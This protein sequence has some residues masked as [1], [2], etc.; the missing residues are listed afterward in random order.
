MK[1][2]LLALLRPLGW[3][4]AALNQLRRT[5]YRKQI[6][7]SK[8]LPG[9]TISVGNLEVGG[10]GKTPICIELAKHLLEAGYH[11]AILTRG[12]GSGL[13][14]SDSAVLLNKQLILPPQQ[15]SKEFFA[16]EARMQ[17]HHLP[18]VPIIIG[19]K[20]FAAAKRY[21]EKQPQPTHWI[22]EDGFQH[23]Q[24]KRDLDIVLLDY[25]KPLD[26][27]RCLPAGRL[28]EAPWTLSKADL[29]IFTRSPDQP[30]LPA[31]VASYLSKRTS[32]DFASFASSLPYP[33]APDVA[34]PFSLAMS[35]GLL[36]GIAKPAQLQHELEKLSINIKESTI[37]R[38][39]EPL[40]RGQVQAL[41]KRCEQIITTEK[42]Y[43]R[44]QEAFTESLRFLY[45]IPL[46]VKLHKGFYKH[47]NKVQIFT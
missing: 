13:K 24:I 27:G 26:N 44:S 23:L 6:L 20:R 15:G 12:Y 30:Q 9:L 37:L 46:E 16:D 42:D 2:F 17:S 5:L 10:T 35:C 40:S 14:P 41:A 47:F 18:S 4:Y 3:L 32:I 45:L 28:R 8:G 1:T 36:A 11:P 33:A 21:L 29:V 19:A 39:H 31:A 38:D 34:P 43:F 25:L 22:L 7:S